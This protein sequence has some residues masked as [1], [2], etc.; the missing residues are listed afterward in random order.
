MPRARP[1]T[2]P[3]ARVSRQLSQAGS[4]IAIVAAVGLLVA[5]CSGGS[6]DHAAPGHI[7]GGEV[8]SPGGPTSQGAGPT[9]VSI[10]PLHRNGRAATHLDVQNGNDYGGRYRLFST[11]GT[12]PGEK[13]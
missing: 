3:L 9:A 13:L 5:G 11:F 1:V 2:R 8:A 7:P 10:S 6:H 4:A 12:A